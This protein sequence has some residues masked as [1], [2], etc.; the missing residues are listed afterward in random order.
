MLI[1]IYLM[2][3][4]GFVI[5]I[6]PKFLTYINSLFNELNININTIAVSHNINT[7]DRT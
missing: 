2:K 7:I 4:R 6:H 3:N 1:I 5:E